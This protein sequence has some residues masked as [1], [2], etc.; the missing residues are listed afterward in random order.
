M[1]KIRALSVL[2]AIAFLVQVSMTWLVQLKLV[3]DYTVAEVSDKY[4][5]LFTPAGITF[6]I[7]GIIYAGLAG[8]CI[9]H[10]VMA[11]KKWTN[12]ATNADT[13]RMGE[14]F[15]LSNVTAAFWLLAWVDEEIGLSV[16][17]MF[18]QLLCLIII[19]RRLGI[20]DSRR[21]VASK[22]LTQFPLSIY[23]GWITVATIAN[24]N[25]YLNSTDWDGWGLDPVDWTTILIGVT[26]FISVLVM[27]IRRNIFFGL[28]VIWAL[29]GII[30]KLSA[31]DPILYY[32]IL[33]TA[34]IG[35]SVLAL[36]AVLRII[37]NWVSVKHN[38]PFPVASQSLK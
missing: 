8:L 33:R 15:V 21:S 4:P 26:V 27:T 13:E 37:K 1:K 38:E 28:V 11:W 9:Y 14:W 23:F 17:L 34:W 19:N 6:A 18:V 7:W 25:C 5:S 35:I 10:I 3:N 32:H 16:V 29:Y 20:Y 31:A 12:H 24:L 30:I 22:L 36:V 2:N